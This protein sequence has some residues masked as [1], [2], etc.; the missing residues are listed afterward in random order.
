MKRLTL[1]ARTPTA[2]RGAAYKPQLCDNISSKKITEPNLA[3]ARAS[4]GTVCIFSKGNSPLVYLADHVLFI[5]S[6]NC[7]PY[8][9]LFFQFH[10]FSKNHTS[11]YSITRDPTCSSWV[12]LVVTPYFF[13]GG[14][15]I[16]LFWKLPW[17]CMGGILNAFRQPINYLRH[18]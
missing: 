10:I 17:Y 4:Y 11:K 16:W 8:G 9:D 1:L 3:A 7:L 12:N 14:F 6:Y 5:F 2:K 18:F 13:D 15:G